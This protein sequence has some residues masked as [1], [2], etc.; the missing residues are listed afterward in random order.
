M[1]SYT[2]SHLNWASV[3]VGGRLGWSCLLCTDTTTWGN[4]MWGEMR[5]PCVDLQCVGVMCVSTPEA[6]WGF[7]DHMSVRQR[8]K[9]GGGGVA[10]VALFNPE[11]DAPPLTSPLRS[12]LGSPMPHLL[13]GQQPGSA[14]W[15]KTRL[16][17][18]VSRS[19]RGN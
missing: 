1:P 6:A 2:S 17:F 4:G 15:E 5:A 16:Y 18:N 13:G 12:A 3:R 11:E 14:L 8:E 19:W 9:V 7:Q 10:A